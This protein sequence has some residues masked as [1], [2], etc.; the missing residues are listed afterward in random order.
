VIMANN[1]A[2]DP[3]PFITTVPVGMPGNKTIYAQ[4]NPPQLYSG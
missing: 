1:V 2:S 3:F 4:P